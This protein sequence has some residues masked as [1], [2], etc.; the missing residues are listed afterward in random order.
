M[1]PWP[2]KTVIGLTGNIATGKSVVR[3]MLEHLGASSIDADALSHRAIAR[4]APGY[5]EVVKTFGTYMLGADGE[6]DRQRLGRLAFADPE[7]LARLEEIIHPLVQQAVDYLVRRARQPV[8]VIE[9]IKLLESPLARL[10]D[11]LWVADA[12]EALQLQRL[13]TKRN[14]S[15]AE[16]RR[17]IAGQNAPA[18]KLRLANVVI[19]NSGSFEDTWL[20]VQAA[21]EGLRRPAAPPEPAP[22]PVRPGQV[23]VLR[24]RP[25]H[26]AE[27]A[28]FIQRASDDRRQLGRGEVIAAFGEKAYHLARVGPELVGLAGW[29]VEN[30]VTRVDELY[31]RPGAVA[32]R[33][34]LQLVQAVESASQDLMSEA[35]LLFITPA[36]AQQSGALWRQAGYEQK[37]PGALGVRA[38]EEAARESMPPGTVLYFKRLRED[39]VLQPV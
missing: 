23:E 1:I 25:G 16:A 4:G 20:Q 24:A 27:I 29:K 17:R 22:R 2:D 15:E 30:L 36:Q 33:V 10:C 3:K 37:P 8:V 5:A 14:L 34:L 19:R 32:V 12:P 39:R 18:G 13:V 6:I 28:A 11:T 9:A 38:W 7:A 35:A 26:A 21:W 31:S